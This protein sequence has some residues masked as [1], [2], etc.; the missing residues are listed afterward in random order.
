MIGDFERRLLVSL[1]QDDRHIMHAGALRRAP[2]PL[3]GDDLVGVGDAN[4]RAHE[5]RLQDAAFF[6]RGGKFLE[7]GFVEILARIARI[8]PQELDRHETLASQPVDCRGFG[9]G[10]ADQR[11][12]SAPKP[13]PCFLCH[14][15]PRCGAQLPF[16]P[17]HLRGEPDIGLA[18][19]AADVVE[20]HRLP[21]RRRLRHAHV[22]GDDRLIDLVAH[23]AT[24]IGD[25]LAG[26]G[27]CAGQTSSERRH[28]STGSG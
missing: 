20:Q 8:G 16:A 11:R 19:G 15:V 5:D 14:C 6:D 27:C 28:G 26:R 3:A 21:V 22:A 1:D 4:D 25:N 10:I 18:A 2:A 7:L 23:E 13:R 24:N 9:A 12:Q 17:D